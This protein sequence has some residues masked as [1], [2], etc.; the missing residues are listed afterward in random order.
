MSYP[1]TDCSKLLGNSYAQQ[2][3]IELYIHGLQR[4][5]RKKYF[6]LCNT[7]ENSNA[8]AENFTVSL[9]SY[10]SE[11]GG[12]TRSYVPRLELHGMV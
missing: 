2:K 5:K 4:K 10:H 9:E 6:F 8:T 1:Q 7:F 11:V 3:A 12:E